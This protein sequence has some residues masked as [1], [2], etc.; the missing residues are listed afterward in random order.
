MPL[1]VPEVNPEAIAA[2]RGIIANPN[3]S[4]IIMLVA[5]TPLYREAGIE[6]IVVSTYQ[7]VSGAGAGAMQELLQ[8]VRDFNEGRPLTAEMLPTASA[9]HHHPILVLNVIPQVDVFAEDGYTKEEWKLVRETHKV[10]GDDSVGVTAD[11]GARACAAQSRRKH[12][13]TDGEPLSVERGRQL[14]TEAPGVV[15]VDEPD[16]MRY[17]MPLDATGKDSVCRPHSQRSDYRA[18]FER[19]GCRRPTAQRRGAERSANRGTVGGAVDEVMMERLQRRGVGVC[20]SSCKN[21]AVRPS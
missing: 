11:D 12:Q 6:R 5:L 13:R 4:T 8:Q 19:M 16:A 3:C 20:A 7:A 10:W 17:P 18:G 21:S 9:E 2:H 14:L 15:V 1:I